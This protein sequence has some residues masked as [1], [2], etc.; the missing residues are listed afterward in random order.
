MPEY[1]TGYFVPNEVPEADAIGEVQSGQQVI[2][3]V[4][5]TAA[6][7]TGNQGVQLEEAKTDV[8]TAT[9]K[10]VYESE[11]VFQDFTGN[12]KNTFVQ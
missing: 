6:A 2:A 12:H 8:N 4:E 3:K 11:K 7:A 1:K 5:S 9:G 10:I